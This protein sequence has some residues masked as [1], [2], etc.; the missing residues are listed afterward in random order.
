MLVSVQACLN[1]V[2]EEHAHAALLFPY[3]H[4]TSLIG[5]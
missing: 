1:E 2:V 4:K 3:G 5:V